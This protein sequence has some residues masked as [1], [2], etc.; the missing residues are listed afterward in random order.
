MET[1]EINAVYEAFENDILKACRE[2]A[3]RIAIE[4]FGEEYDEEANEEFSK[5]VCE[6]SMCL[7]GFKPWPED[8]AHYFAKRIDEINEK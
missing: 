8:A 4:K 5:L 2:E 3:K 7:M 6:Y 1:P